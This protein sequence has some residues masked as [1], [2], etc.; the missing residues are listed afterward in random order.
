M[1]SINSKI[2]DR[3]NLQQLIEKWRLSNEKIVFTNGCFDIIHRGHIDYLSKSAALGTKLIIGLNTDASVRK[4]KGDTRPIQDEQSRQ[5]ILSAFQFVDAVILFDE[6]TPYELINAV[7]P[8][9]LVKGSDYKPEEIVG[10]DIVKAK[11]G[12]VITIDYL[13]GFSTSAIEKKIKQ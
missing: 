2:I 7:Q 8:D 5:I 6:E 3:N 1:Q 11:N 12:E 9:I 4:L 10:F 13:P